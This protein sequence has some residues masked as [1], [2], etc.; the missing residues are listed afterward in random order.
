MTHKREKITTMQRVNRIQCKIVLADRER[1]RERE[2]ERER[3]SEKRERE[4]DR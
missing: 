2:T 3:K 4:R 1:E